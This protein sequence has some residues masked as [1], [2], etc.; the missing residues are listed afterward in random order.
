MLLNQFLLVAATLAA[1]TEGEVTYKISWESASNWTQAKETCEGF[2]GELATA[3]N[4]IESDALL[5]EIPDNS[6]PFFFGL[7]EKKPEEAWTWIDGTP[8]GSWNKWYSQPDDDATCAV[9]MFDGS[10]AAATN[11]E[12]GAASI[13][14]ITS[15]GP[16]VGTRVTAC[17]GD[18]NLVNGEIITGPSDDSSLV[19]VQWKNGET[20][21]YKYAEKCG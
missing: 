21:S 7:K 15:E 18:E 11:C 20:G 13:C 5:D 6:G 10:W 4:K 3:K 1:V 16:S 17:N 19:T 2:G 14:K 9:L 8:L 12:E